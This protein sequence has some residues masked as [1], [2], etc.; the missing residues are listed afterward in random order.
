[1]K[2]N[3][4]RFGFSNISIKKSRSSTAGMDR[5]FTKKENRLILSGEIDEKMHVLQTT[6]AKEKITL[7]KSSTEV[8][9]D[10]PLLDV[11]R[12]RMLATV[13]HPSHQGVGIAAP[14]V[15][16]NRNLIW[17]QRFDK[18]DQPFEFY[19]NPQIIWYSQLLRKG[20][21]GCLS[22][23]DRKEDIIRHY[24][25]KI[26]YINNKTGSPVEE[27]IEGFTAIIFQHEIDHLH[28]I[29]YPDRLEEQLSKDVLILNKNIEF[30]VE[31]ETFTP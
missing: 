29:L 31:K 19:I 7:Y 1:M 23:P 8:Q 5:Y 26:Q 3:L 9:Y 27:L 12:N 16:I 4:C 15:G 11:L 14:Q 6:V 18:I 13:Q 30:S 20:T 2:M 21:E 28:G 17:V 24:A 22:I 10:A 25:I